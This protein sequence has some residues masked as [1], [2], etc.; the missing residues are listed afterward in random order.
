MFPSG[1]D[2]ITQPIPSQPRRR[3]P[4]P[5][6]IKPPPSS[7][8]PRS[9]SQHPQHPIISANIFA[10]SSLSRP[11]DTYSMSTDATGAPSRLP[12]PYRD[13]LRPKDNG[14]PLMPHPLPPS[15]ATPFSAR[16]PPLTP[17]YL[18]ST[19]SHMPILNLPPTPIALGLPSLATPYR[20]FSIQDDLTLPPRRTFSNAFSSDSDALTR[21]A[22]SGF[23]VADA[24]NKR[25]RLHQVQRGGLDPA[26]TSFKSSGSNAHDTHP[27]TLPS[28]AHNPSHVALLRYKRLDPPWFALPLDR[29]ISQ[30]PSFY[31]GDALQNHNPLQYPLPS[32]SESSQVNDPHNSILAPMHYS[33]PALLTSHYN[34]LLATPSSPSPQPSHLPLRNH[35]QIVLSSPSLHRIYGT[36]PPHNYS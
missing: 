29:P 8:T 23:D 36:E 25:R 1:S 20:S 10:P 26:L 28:Y 22:A 2:A 3:P 32:M 12:S 18:P 34:P 9:S 7:S 5:R 4:R 6:P 11:D 30:G 24:L 14:I 13:P 15:L 31:P 33:A 17:I 27:V 19:P 35:E 16:V 21:A